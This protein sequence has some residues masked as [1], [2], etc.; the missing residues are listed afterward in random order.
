[1]HSDPR[2]TRRRR[3]PARQLLLSAAARVF[4]RDGLDGATTR[5]IS[6]EAGV[7]EVTLFRHFG[8]KEHLIEAVVGSAFGGAGEPSAGPGRGRQRLRADLAAFARRYEALLAAN[9]A[10]IRT[11]IGEIHRHALCEQQAL[12]GI[13]WPMRAALVE[14]LSLARKTGE[15]RTG[16]DPEIGAD[17]FAGAIMASVLRRANSHGQ[18]EYSA[19]HYRSACVDVFLSGIRG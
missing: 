14:R 4:A 2:P 18:R 3:P 7:N 15:A 1:M 11:M 19:T 17:I 9:M 16:I 5:A 13:F 10:L 6:R 8:T 12:K